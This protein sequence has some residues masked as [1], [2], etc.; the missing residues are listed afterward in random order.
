M[1]DLCVVQIQP[2]KN[3][4]DHA[5]NTT[6]TLQHELDHTHHTDHTDHV[7]YVYICPEGSRSRDVGVDDLSKARNLFTINIAR[8]TTAL[9]NSR[10]YVNG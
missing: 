3:G 8:A 2:R 4:L 9:S 5:D 1:Q 7:Q 6:L 10:P